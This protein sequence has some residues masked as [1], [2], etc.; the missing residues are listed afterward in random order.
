[1]RDTPR[2]KAHGP[3]PHGKRFRVVLVAADGTRRPRSFASEREALDYL[4]IWREETDG[5]TLAGAVDAYLAHLR[6]R[7]L[8]AATVTTTKH[9]LHGLLR[10]VEQDRPLGALTP[11]VAAALWRH[12]C[13]E[14]VTD[15]QA[16]ELA[17]AHGFAAWC[18]E[19]G[20]L[21]ADPFDGLAP[22]GKR[23]AGKPQLRIDEA[24][25]FLDR[26]L[27]DEN[28]R[29]GLAAALALVMGMRASEITG[30]V[31][32][33]VDDGARVLWIERAK[34]RHGDRTLEV[35]EALRPRLAELVAG[36]GGGEPLFGDVDRH[37]LGYHVRRICRA[38][39]VPVV[40]PHGLRGTQSSIA[41]PA[42]PVEHV[43]AALGHGGTGIT[44]RHYIAKGAEQDGRQRAALRV[45][46]GGAR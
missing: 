24:R 42:V 46:T 45:I 39:K 27:D 10:V 36:R 9:R 8:R 25:R 18:R 15:T 32:R 33:D 2:E 26:A 21:R 7:G 35:P 11:A 23:R 20:W 43:A 13:G 30:R 4:A 40:P 6:S 31:V 34:T 3:Y 14:V 22:S 12:R 5:R 17:A 16:G 1:M 44:R 28:R 37:W 29:A 41:A 38:A 19:Q